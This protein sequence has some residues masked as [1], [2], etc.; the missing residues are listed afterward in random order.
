VIS[1]LTDALLTQALRSALTAAERAGGVEL[2]AWKD[3][4]IAAAIR[5]IHQ[6]PQR[7]WTVDELASRA[8]LSRSTFSTRFRQL[9]G[10]PPMRYA[11]QIRLAYAAGLLHSTRASLTEIARRTGYDDEF[12]LSRAFKRAYGVA[13]GSYRR[14]VEAPAPRLVLD[15]PD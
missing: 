15:R 12:S 3:P 14:R 9:V 6:Q 13:P 2:P 4:R 1:R 11:N 5:L 10:E 8:G 7:A